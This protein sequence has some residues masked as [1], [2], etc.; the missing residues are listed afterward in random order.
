MRRPTIRLAYC[1]GMRRWACS[2]KTTPAMMRDADDQRRAAKVNG[3]VMVTE[4]CQSWPG[5]AAMIEVKI[6]SDM[7]LPTPRSVISS[8]SHM[9]TRGAGGHREI[10]G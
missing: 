4:I 8:P 3:A 1:T 6:S 10:I 2:T 5:K 7:P 9:M